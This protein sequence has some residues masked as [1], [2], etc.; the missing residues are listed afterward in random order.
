MRRGEGERSEERGKGASEEGGREGGGDKR[1][2]G[3]QGGKWE[4]PRGASQVFSDVAFPK[5]WISFL[6]T[7]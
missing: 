3:G 4:R 5:Q 2:V 6:P 1:R 7:L